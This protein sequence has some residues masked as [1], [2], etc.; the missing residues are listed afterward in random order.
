[1]IADQKFDPYPFLSYY[2]VQAFHSS[3]WYEEYKIV[4]KRVYHLEAVH[5]TARLKKGAKENY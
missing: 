5:E 1:M 3:S 2:F 4:S